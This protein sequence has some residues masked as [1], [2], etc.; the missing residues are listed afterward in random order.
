MSTSRARLLA[1]VF[2]LVLAPLAAA[3]QTSRLVVEVEGGPAWQSYNDVRIPNDASATRFSLVD[4]VGTGPAAAGRVYVTWNTSERNG[5][6]LLVAPFTLEATGVLDRP[7][8][9][10]GYTFQAGYGARARYTFNSYRLTWRHRFHAG[11][12]TTAWIGLT[13]KVRDAT[14]SLAQG[15]VLT[16]KDDLGFVP[17]LHFAGEWRPAP[18]WRLELD[19]DAVAGGPG[20]AEDATIRVGR[21]LGDRW[22]LRAGYRMVEGGADVDAVYTFAWLHYAVV[23]I[24]WRR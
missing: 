24:A 6:R 13:A 15:K 10:A 8:T 22:T 17:L 16:R 21:D 18:R 4:L 2:P 12:R 19:A 1:P 9:F 20:R 3:A 7:I 5:W 11:E 14:I 23:S